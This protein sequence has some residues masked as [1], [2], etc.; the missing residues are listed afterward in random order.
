MLMTKV[1][2]DRPPLAQGIQCGIA[3]ISTVARTGSPSIPRSKSAFERSHRVIIPHVLIDLQYDARA[4]TGL[5]ERAGLEVIHRQRF[6][7]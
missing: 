6:L 4:G 3:R 1:E 5:D 2:S 7:R